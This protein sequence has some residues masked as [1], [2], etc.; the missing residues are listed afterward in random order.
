MLRNTL[1][2]ALR[3][4]TRNAFYSAINVLGL[5]AALAVALLIGLYVRDQFNYEHF[6]RGYGQIYLLSAFNVPP[7][8]HAAI[9]SL[10]TQPDLLPWIRAD[11]P[12]VAQAA[13]LIANRQTLRRGDFEANERVFWADPGF[14]A[15][16]PLPAIAGD[17]ATALSRPDGLVITREIARKYFGRDDPIGATLE[18]SRTTR[19]TVTAVLQDLPSNTHLSAK[20]FAS[21][22]AQASPQYALAASRQAFGG[23][24]WSAYSYVQLRPGARVAAVAARIPGILDR[25]VPSGAEKPI[26]TYL[27]ITLIPLTEVHFD[28]EGNNAMKPASPRETIYALT[29]VAA[30]ILTLAAI[31][32]VNLTTA[33]ALS[34]VGEVGVRKAS[35]AR[36][37]DL[38]IQFVTEG[39]LYVAMAAVIA[40]AAAEAVLP[41]LNG[42]LGSTIPFA[43]W[44]DAALAAV[45]AFAL[46]A[47]ALLASA[48]PALLLSRFNPARVLGKGN[49]AAHTHPARIRRLLVTG[50][51][52]ILIGLIVTVIVVHRQMSFAIHDSLRLKTDQVLAIRLGCSAEVG[53]FRD[54][55]AALPGV[56]DAAC[57]S[58]VPPNPL[59]SASPGLRRDAQAEVHGAMIQYAAVDFGFFDVYGLRPVAG[60]FH[61]RE[62]P[63]DAANTNTRAS[64]PE[65]IVIN[66]T[67]V[68]TLGF[69]SPQNAIGSTVIWTHALADAAPHGRHPC[70]IIGVVPDFEI[71]SIREPIE[72]A[73]FFVDAAQARFLNVRLRPGP[74]EPTLQQIDTLWARFSDRRPLNR[75][76]VDAQT[77]LKYEDITRQSVLA[78]LFAGVA[79]LIAALGL[80]ALSAYS[81]QRRTKEIGVRKALGA[82]RYQIS[83]QLVWEF[84]TPVLWANVIALP[85]AGYFMSR[86]LGTFAYRIDLTPGAFL[87]AATT[88]ILIATVT[89]GTHAFRVAS[90]KPGL[91]LRHD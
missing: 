88:A 19:M 84:L 47:F 44:T 18:I 41:A 49:I 26:S 20:V 70:L 30:L 50:Q 76:F 59:G 2:G 80:L 24:V 43:Y 66:E 57:S 40:A 17:L 68:R 34:R 5:S 3:N 45:S 28:T 13:R 78:S 46:C 9:R 37:R 62:H 82:S 58:W 53:G 42:F 14:F 39:C 6:I 87:L 33:R 38:V 21:A 16:V 89:I 10:T 63:N 77:R 65:A 55:V 73:A 60:R 69:A 51:F 27:K 7:E 54:A 71:S 81:A 67:A 64:G 61:S 86:W 29:A 72:S 35:G 23:R 25:R 75:V 56:V 79:V 36:R 15:V 74:V 11:A 85:L 52:A 1:A 4:L 22:L 8:G 83:T 12:E 31:N 90:L 48:Y 91:A 32:F